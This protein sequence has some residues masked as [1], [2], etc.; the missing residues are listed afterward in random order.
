MRA[1]VPETADRGKGKRLTTELANGG[2]SSIQLPSYEEVQKDLK[3][4]RQQEGVSV[5]RISSY[6]RNLQQLRISQEE[7]RRSGSQPGTL[8]LATI[9]ALEC[10]VRSYDPE[11]VHFTI[12]DTTL[13]FRGA[14]ANLTDR[15][16][17]VM[18]VLDVYSKT[19]YELYERNTY[20]VFAF[21]LQQ[22]EKSFCGQKE[23]AATAIAKLPFD[24]R[25]AFIQV[26]LDARVS[27]LPVNGNVLA[28]DVVRA[29]PGLS[30]LQQLRGMSPLE[31]LD[32]V[33]ITVIEYH[34]R[35]PG[36][37]DVAEFHLLGELMHYYNGRE[38]SLPGNALLAA[39]YDVALATLMRKH[40]HLRIAQFGQLSSKTHP[41]ELQRVAKDG[42]F[43]K[44][45]APTRR[46]ELVR[47]IAMGTLAYLLVKFDKEAA[48]EEL[49]RDIPPREG[50]FSPQ[51]ALEITKAL[52]PREDREQ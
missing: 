48:W 25:V 40:G 21:R 9:A 27:M 35:K 10:A 18:N 42:W 7:F 36:K 11:S 22:Q 12:L 19:T 5:R 46:F 4:V 20:E 8:P 30:S 33:L 13:N 39:T 17:T 28:E 15:Q 23:D 44:A 32:R 45:G 1:G 29:L 16:Q 34:V 3:R 24:E 38:L 26:L 37:Y 2:E 41:S 51:E 49:F 14:N 6:G 43:F 47:F 52:S 50:W 31:T